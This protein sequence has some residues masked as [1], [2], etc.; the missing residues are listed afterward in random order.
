M[1]I[2]SWDSLSLAQRVELLQRPEKDSSAPLRSYVSGLINQVRTE[3]D[4]GLRALTLRFDQ[5]QVSTFKVSEEVRK[6]AFADLPEQTLRALEVAIKNIRRFHEA[7]KLEDLSI[8][9]QAG[10][11][12]EKRYMP[13]RKVGIYIPAGSAPLF[14]TLMMLAIPAKIAGCEEIVLCSPPDQAT[15]EIN[16]TILAVAELLGVTQIFRAG[17][18]QAVAAMAYGTESIPKVDKIFGPGNAYVTEAKI[19]VSQDPLGASIDMPAGPSEVLVIGD[20]TSSPRFIASDLLSQAEH[21]CLSQV[22]LVSTDEALLV[23]TQEE[24]QRQ[25]ETLP[26][27]EIAQKSLDSSRFIKAKNLSQAIEIS[28]QYAPEHLIIQ[29]DLPRSVADKI[30]NAGSVFIGPWTP[31]AVGDYA[32]GTNH[33]LP[34]YGHARAIGGVGVESF[35]KSIFFQELTFDALKN[36]SPCVEAL[37]RLEGLEAHSRAVSIRLDS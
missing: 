24:I 29:T 11:C 32:S 10:V 35:M 2:Y 13:I 30:R 33:V 9:T 36:L 22:I 28:D 37:A 31:E 1:K 3:G 16:P 18:A 21:D 20:K 26:R 25:I 34:T 5:V 19:Q 23:S 12:C 27:K 15:N 14:S 4:Q 17:G 7:Q 6:K 8:E